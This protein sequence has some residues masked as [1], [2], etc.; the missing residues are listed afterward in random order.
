[1]QEDGDGQLNH[2]VQHHVDEED[3]ARVLGENSVPEEGM[4]QRAIDVVDGD[5]QCHHKHVF[6]HCRCKSVP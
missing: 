5:A 1:M 4:N 3:V 2:V 6:G